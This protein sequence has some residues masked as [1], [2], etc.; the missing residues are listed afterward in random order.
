MF[1]V[2]VI[3]IGLLAIG[4][5]VWQIY[6]IQQDEKRVSPPLRVIIPLVIGGISII[7]LIIHGLIANLG[8]SRSSYDWADMFSNLWRVIVLFITF[9][10]KS[11]LGPIFTAL[12][13]IM[14][15]YFLFEYGE[16]RVWKFVVAFFD[17]VFSKMPE[18]VET[19]YLVILFL[20]AIGGSFADGNI[21]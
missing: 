1:A 14:V 5:V 21:D 6:F 3:L 20:T 10:I 18:W 9:S 11:Y 16:F 13:V 4:G 2:E 12:A 15:C 8:D 7:G 19:L 17:W